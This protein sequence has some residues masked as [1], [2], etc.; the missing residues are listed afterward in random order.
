MSE[1][2]EGEIWQDGQQIGQQA[3]VGCQEVRSY[4]DDGFN[5]QGLSLL[6]ILRGNR[7]ACVSVTLT[8]ETR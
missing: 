6:G 3:T 8:W 7:V 2:S 1:G 5:S 4:H